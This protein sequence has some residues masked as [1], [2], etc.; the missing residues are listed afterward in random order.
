MKIESLALVRHIQQI[1]D[2]DLIHSFPPIESFVL[3]DTPHIL[4]VQSHV[5]H[6]ET[7]YVFMELSYRPVDGGKRF[8]YDVAIYDPAGDI[9]YPS[10]LEPADPLPTPSVRGT[11]KQAIPMTVHFRTAGTH[12]LRV[13]VRDLSAPDSDLLARRKLSFDVREKPPTP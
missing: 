7:F 4:L 2:G 5:A 11:Y 1:S 9:I 10:W 6:T 12:E 13:T 3:G 8:R